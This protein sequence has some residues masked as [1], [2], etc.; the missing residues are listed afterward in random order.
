MEAVIYG[1]MGVMLALIL[2]EV[3]VMRHLQK[4]GEPPKKTLHNVLPWP[5]IRK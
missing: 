3:R 1:L 4:T 2:D 5:S